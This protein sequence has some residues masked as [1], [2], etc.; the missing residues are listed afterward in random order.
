MKW[1]EFLISKFKRSVNLNK[2]LVVGIGNIGVDYFKTRHNLGFEALDFI[3]NHFESKFEKQRLGEV[4]KFTFRGKKIVL[5]KPNTYVNLSG[6]S[7]RYWLNKEKIHIENLMVVTDDINLPFGTIRIR[8]K[9]SDGGHNGLKNI[10]EL[11]KTSN[12]NRLRFGIGS[13]FLKKNQSDYVLSKWSETESSELSKLIPTI[14][15]VIC[16]FVL[17]GVTSTMNQYNS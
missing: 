2:Y 1:I 8:T 3:S 10:N 6:K 15:E 5:L 7:V 16:S 9:G 4:S 13:S 14:N 11:L 12:Y 17:S